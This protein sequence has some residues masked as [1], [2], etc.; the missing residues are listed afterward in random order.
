[1]SLNVR[2]KAEVWAEG[3]PLTDAGAGRFSVPR[4][5]PKPVT[6]WLRVE[7]ER[8]FYAGAALDEPILLD[9]GPGL[10]DLGDW[11]R[12]DGL[13]SYSGGAWYRKTVT[14]PEAKQV[15]LNL[16]EI[17]AS[18][19]VRVNGQPAGT[20]VSPPWVLDITRLAKPG[21]NRIEV[22][23]CN[24]LANHYTTMPT[25]Y[26]GPTISGLLGPVQVELR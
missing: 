3:K 22:L 25:G 16:G 1:L 13:L 6:V 19:E 2:G 24:T 7:Q 20:K 8:G 14:I 9:C 17:V 12:N 4:P 10:L 18:V 21:A 5:S 26:R 15:L 23:V 11:S